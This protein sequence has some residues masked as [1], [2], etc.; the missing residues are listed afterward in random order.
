MEKITLN[1]SKEQM[2]MLQELVNKSI[3]KDCNRVWKREI[4]DSLKKE[5]EDAYKKPVM[6]KEELQEQLETERKYW[7]ERN[8]NIA[9][10]H[11]M[12]RAKEDELRFEYE[13]TG[14]EEK[15]CIDDPEEMDP[16][17]SSSKYV[18]L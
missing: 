6:T 18:S 16:Y 3:F 13:I 12:T 4:L 17:V 2:C 1:L 15:I 5:L 7:E 14:E 8:S 10:V 9:L 11:N